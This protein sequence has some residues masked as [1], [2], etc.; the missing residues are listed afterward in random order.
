MV[1]YEAARKLEEIQ[2]LSDD[3]EVVN[4]LRFYHRGGVHKAI[5]KG[6]KLENMFEMAE[7]KGVFFPEE[8]K[9]LLRVIFPDTEVS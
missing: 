2:F 1:K 6:I 9:S 5:E 4:F 8:M 7:N 3:K